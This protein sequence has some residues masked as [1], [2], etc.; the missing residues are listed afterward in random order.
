MKKVSNTLKV[1]KN[2]AVIIHAKKTLNEKKIEKLI[3]KYDDN[4]SKLL[5]NK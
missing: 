5:T 1:K 2:K 4:L 3:K